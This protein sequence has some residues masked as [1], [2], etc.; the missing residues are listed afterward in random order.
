MNK[1]LLLPIS[2]FLLFVYLN[3]TNVYGFLLLL[4]SLIV[5]FKD[6]KIALGILLVWVAVMLNYL[7]DNRKNLQENFQENSIVTTKESQNQE[8]DSNFLNVFVRI[9]GNISNYTLNINKNNT[10]AD[11]I[12]LMENKTQMNL[13]LYKIGLQL[14]SD[15]VDTK[16]YYLNNIENNQSIALWNKN[17]EIENKQAI[18]RLKELVSSEEEYSY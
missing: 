12:R 4:S 17:A 10:F 15:L 13:G 11:V 6:Q 9:K 1:Q 3:K 8:F 14:K 5:Y 7:E 16:Y 2:F 18:E